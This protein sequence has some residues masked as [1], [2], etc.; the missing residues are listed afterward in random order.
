MNLKLYCSECEE[1]LEI[2]NVDELY[3]EIYVKPCETCLE[4]FLDKIASEEG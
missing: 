3:N 1:P 4:L 2:E